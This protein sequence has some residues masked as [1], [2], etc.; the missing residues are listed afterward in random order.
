MFTAKIWWQSNYKVPFMHK[1]IIFLILVFINSITYADTI[2]NGDARFELYQAQLKNKRVALFANSSSRLEQQNIV[3]FLLN[4]NI[5]VT[6]IFT[7]EHGFNLDSDAGMMVNKQQNNSIPSSITIVSL[8]GKKNKPDTQDLKNIDIIVFDIQDVG[9]RYYTYISSLQKLME[10]AVDNNKPLLILDRANPNGF[11]IDGPVLESKYKSF[12]GMQNIPVVYGMTIGEY[13]KM[14]IGENWLDV[15]PKSKAKKLALT[16]IPIK[17]YTHA[18]KYQ[19]ADKPSPNLPNMTAI[20]LYP[21]L[22]WFEGTL[23]SIGRGTSMPFQVIGHPFYKENFSFTPQPMIGARTPALSGQLC[24]G[25]DL[26]N[27]Y[28]QEPPAAQINLGYLI[29]AYN[30]FPQPDKFFTPFFDKLAG[31]NQLRQQL[32]A[33]N[34]ES[35]IRLSWQPKLQKFRQIRNKYLLYP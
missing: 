31:T 17:N 4:H 3:T 30:E 25:W 29:T 15:T 2:I 16:I 19:V 23:L 28:R 18:R 7:P 33:G 24:H 1:I 27:S 22:G 5:K 20:Y 14:L 35:Q 9:V 34:T 11:Y 10:A 32:V 12:V 6:K 8:Y 13:A 26:R 21:H